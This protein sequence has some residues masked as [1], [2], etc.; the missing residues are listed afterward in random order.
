M[1]TTPYKIGYGAE[2]DLHNRLLGLDFEVMRAYKSKGPYDLMAY[3][4]GLRPLLIEVKYYKAMTAT[5]DSDINN[6]AI[7]KLLKKQNSIKLI[8]R[9]K[10]VDSYPLFAFK[11]KGKGYLF[12]R[13]D[14]DERKFMP[15]SKMNDLLYRFLKLQNPFDSHYT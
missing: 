3:T 6:K 1:V 8:A 4:N 14:N 13:L 12:Y 10:S 5:P 11:I 15:Y 9:A 2:N 7:K